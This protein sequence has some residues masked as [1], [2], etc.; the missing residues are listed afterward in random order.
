M[1]LVFDSTTLI[2]FSK[3]KMLD[4]LPKL[5][6][7]RVI[8]ETVYNEVVIEGKNKGKEDALFIEKLINRNVFDVIKAKNKDF[9]NHLLGI[10]SIDCADA[11][12]LALAKELSGLAI[13]DETPSRNIAEIENIKFHGSVFL[14]FLLH[15]EKLISKKE[16]KAYIDKMVKL[17]WRC[18]TEFYAAILTE[19]EKL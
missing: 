6:A 16:V 9:I 15:K 12:T 11:E 10:P 8:P 3:L 4:K 17:G 18:S 19:I 2:Y 1:I 7:G 13:I 5:R 14:L